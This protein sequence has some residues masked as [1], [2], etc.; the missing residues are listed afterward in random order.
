MN[1][2]RFKRRP[3]GR[4]FPSFPHKLAALC[5]G[6]LSAQV[7]FAQG[8]A[9]GYYDSVDSSS[10]SALRSTLHGVIDDHLRFPYTS[11]NTDTWDILE[12]VQEDPSDPARIIDVY[13]NDDHLKQGGGNTFYNREHTWPNSYGFP[14]DGSGNYPFTDCHVLF[15]CDSSYNSSRGNKPYRTCGPSCSEKT[16]VANSGQGGGSGNYPGNSNWTS[17]LHST[18]SWE[19]W[20]A[21]RGDIA[22][23]QFY[24]DVRYEGGVH[25]TTGHWE[26]NLILTNS[27]SLIA[28][29]NTGNN[30]AVA[31]MGMLQDLLQWHLED[32]VDDRERA[33]NDIVFSYQGNRNPFIDHPEW[34]DCLFQAACETTP[35]NAYCFGDGSGTPCPCGNSSAPDEGCSNSN[36]MG[37]TL[38]ATGSSSLLTD[39]LVLHST[40]LTSGPGL[41]FQGNNAINSG[42]GN[43]F[44]DGLRCVG[45]NIIRL[46]VRFSTFGDSQTTISIPAA[47]GVSA[48]DTKRYQLWYR[49][50]GTSPCNSLFNL[51]NAYRVTWTL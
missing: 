3:L 8:P 41:Y 24:L 45:G 16:T 35:G 12:Q 39:D 49:D 37:A 14:D 48:G 5:A 21:T 7:A 46:Q 33:R 15:L 36:G 2:T 34:A 1:L 40:Q 17:G 20:G 10:Q 23:A 11:S 4:P 18:G 25:G 13:Q 31:Y 44:G 47:G 26:P 29:S 30:E 19:V 51:T 32:P 6:F 50:A 27:E 43:P 9:A 42:N 38:S 22:R 28:A